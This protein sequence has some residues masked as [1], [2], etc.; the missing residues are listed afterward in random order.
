MIKHGNCCILDLLKGKFY[1][2]VM[3]ISEKHKGL[4]Y[5]IK[6]L[7]RVCY[8]CV[9]ECPSKAIKIINGQA[10]V[11]QERCIGC[12]NCIKVCSQDAKVFVQ[13]RLEVRDLLK[14]THRVVAIVAPSFPASFSDID[15]YRKLVGMLRS[16][17]F[18]H[19]CEVAFGADLVAKKYK[20]YLEEDT[21]R[22]FISSDCPAIVDYI[23]YYHPSLVSHL[24]PVVS[25]MVAMSKVVKELYGSDIKV[26]FIGPCIAKK[27]ESY[28]VDEVLTFREIRTMFDNAG[29]T[30][31]GVT[32]S[33]FDPPK[34]GRGAIFPITRGLIQTVNI[35]DD[36]FEGNVIVADG[37]VNFQ[38]A[39]KEFECGN[40]QNVNLELLCCEGCI[41]GP[42]MP[43][44]GSPYERRTHISSYVRGKLQSKEDMLLWEENIERFS[45]INL[46]VAFFAHDQRLNQ[47]SEEDVSKVLASMGKFSARDHLNCGACG[48]DTCLEHAVAIVEGL[49]EVEMCLP[50]SID[51]LHSTIKNLAISNEK[52]A[53]IQQAL[54]QSE[55]LAHMGQLSAGIAHELN[56]PLGVLIMYTN[57]LLE[58]CKEND[59][60][61][62][63]LELIATQAERCKKIVSGLLNFARKN[64][65]RFEE[66]DIVKLAEDSLNSVVI[67]SSISTRV[68]N[69]TENPLAQIDYDQMMQ[70]LTN[71]NKNAIESMPTGGNLEIVVEDT[72]ELITFR[73]KDTGHGIA[74]E[75]MDK[76]FTPFFT[77]KEVGKGTGL[78]LATS[79]GIVK[80]HKGKI[81][82]R[83]NSNKEKG[84]TG[85]TFSIILPRKP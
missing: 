13:S 17:G 24:V 21:E 51:E 69:R 28:E 65:V 66:A 19:V 7:C 10:E 16:L 2:K 44:G 25:P 81:E 4:V 80:M 83:S 5:T 53:T 36:L 40:I 12:G 45:H 39:I 41:M 30:A 43:P 68:V 33:D 18:S 46:D 63:D 35:P 26:V 15:D 20:K 31:D 8:T 42:G 71:L 57:I 58:E 64:Q 49:A 29:I 22:G 85:T 37:R 67:P 73:V 77:T 50:Y 62:Q 38:Q 6:E 14:S 82:V 47:P 61:R 48:Y 3:G 84:P 60:N 27:D 76:L 59:P 78:G 55:K 1:C 23:R 75:D 70:V 52:L 72:P 9:R 54:R 74:E 79:Y 11:L 32:P 34:A 56:N